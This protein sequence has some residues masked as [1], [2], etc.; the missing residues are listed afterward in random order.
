MILN[1]AITKNTPTKNENI[2]LS[3]NIMILS[4]SIV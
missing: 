4:L 1:V 2:E 3:D